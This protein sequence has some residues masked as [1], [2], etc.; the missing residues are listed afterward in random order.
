[1]SNISD[2]SVSYTLSLSSN[3]KL[4]ALEKTLHQSI[5]EFQGKFIT[6]Y[7]FHIFLSIS[8]TIPAVT[9]DKN[10]RNSHVTHELFYLKL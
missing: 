1:M 4:L 5:I 3:S 10:S 7:P 8:L 9:I 6:F 2:D